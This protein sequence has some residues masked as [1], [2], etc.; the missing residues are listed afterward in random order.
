MK[1]KKKFKLL[2]LLCYIDDNRE[3]FKD[4]K[5]QFISDSGFNFV[6]IDSNNDISINFCES[7]N[8]GTTIN[9]DLF[10]VDIDIDVKTHCFDLLQVYYISNNTKINYYELKNSSIE[11][12]LIYFSFDYV[13]RIIYDN[14]V[15][16]ENGN[17]IEHE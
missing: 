11:N 3:K 1:I 5:I 8:Y 4:K 12:V 7:N 6:V 2:D 16:F 17:V 9:N 15:I 14:K 10:T 13:S